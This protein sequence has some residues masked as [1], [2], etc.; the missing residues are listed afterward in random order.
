[1]FTFCQDCKMFEELEICI[2]MVMRVGS[3]MHSLNQ[4]TDIDLR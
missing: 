3:K 1:M 4:T 2:L